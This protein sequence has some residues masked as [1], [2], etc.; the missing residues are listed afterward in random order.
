[1]KN[2][3]IHIVSILIK[4]FNKELKGH[5]NADL[6]LNPNSNERTL[7]GNVNASMKY[8]KQVVVPTGII[9]KE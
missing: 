4:S 8:A 6:H 1:L 3:F 7:I 2:S 9:F 5:T